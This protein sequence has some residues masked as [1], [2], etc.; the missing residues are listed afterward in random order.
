MYMFLDMISLLHNYL[1]YTYMLF[2]SIVWYFDTF[3][4]AKCVFG[5]EGWHFGSVLSCMF[6]K[7]HKNKSIEGKFSFGIN[8]SGKCLA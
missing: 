8:I 1:M 5:P 4:V 7:L 2:G 3:K 6:N